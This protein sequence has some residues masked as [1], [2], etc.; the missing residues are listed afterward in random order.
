[1]KVVC[2]YNLHPSHCGRSFFQVQRNVAG[3]AVA[4]N[5]SSSRTRLFFCGGGFGGGSPRTLAI[6][7]SLYFSGLSPNAPRWAKLHEQINES[8]VKPQVSM[9]SE[10]TPIFTISACFHSLPPLPPTAPLATLYLR[11]S[12]VG[13]SAHCWST[14]PRSRYATTWPSRTLRWPLG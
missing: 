14:N 7:F 12:E 2:K 6:L 3:G 9:L 5:E 10:H 13:L 11:V 8:L 1:M 4:Q